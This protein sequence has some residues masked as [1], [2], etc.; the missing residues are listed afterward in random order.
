MT[1]NTLKFDPAVSILFYWIRFIQCR[2]NTNIFFII[3]LFPV[4]KFKIIFVTASGRSLGAGSQTR[5][6]CCGQ[7]QI[8]A[9]GVWPGEVSLFVKNI[10]SQLKLHCMR[11]NVNEKV[12]RGF[13]AVFTASEAKAI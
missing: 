1:A 2:K 6:M 12:V 5:H 7:P 4:K 9:P 13:K 11:A 3:I 8:H 10:K